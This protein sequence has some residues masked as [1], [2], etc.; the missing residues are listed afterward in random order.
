MWFHPTLRT[1]GP[2]G[3]LSRRGGGTWVARTYA[4]YEAY[5]FPLGSDFLIV[6]GSGRRIL[7]SQWRSVF[8]GTNPKII[9][10]IGGI[11]FWLVLQSVGA[12]RLLGY[13]LAEGVGR[14]AP[15]ASGRLAR[16]H[17]TGDPRSSKLF[18]LRSDI[19]S[20]ASVGIDDLLAFQIEPMRRLRTRPMMGPP[21]GK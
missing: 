10:I 4:P 13:A 19:L 3:R 16:Q 11:G 21:N 1:V 6:L 2:R 12:F 5:G 17:E 8:I 15:L 18:E 7:C 14:R 20:P 9:G